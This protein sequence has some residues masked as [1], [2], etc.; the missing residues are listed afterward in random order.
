M[1][2]STRSTRTTSTRR[3]QGTPASTGAPVQ[4]QH[5][6]QRGNRATTNQAAT[7]ATAAATTVAADQRPDVP[8][9]SPGQVTAT[10]S[11]PSV[12]QASTIPANATPLVGA[13]DPTLLQHDV[14][15]MWAELQEL[16]RQFQHTSSYNLTLTSC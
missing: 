4:R 7:A 10:T 1:A 3:A 8:S 12:A 14:G 9:N 6:G 15:A 2:S 5:Q 11:G 16:R 13:I